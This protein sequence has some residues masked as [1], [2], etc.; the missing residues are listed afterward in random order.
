MTTPMRMGLPTKID[1]AR[2]TLA[3]LLLGAVG[4]LGRSLSDTPGGNLRDYARNCGAL[5]LLGLAAGLTLA[6]G[7]ASFS[8]VLRAPDRG[9]SR[10]LPLAALALNAAPWILGFAWDFLTRRA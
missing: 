8:D 6:G 9:R 1:F 5:A 10:R 2:G 3:L 7:A 4:A